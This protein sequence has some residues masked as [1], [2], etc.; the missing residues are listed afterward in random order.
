MKKQK[1]IKHESRWVN[2][3]EKVSIKANDKVNNKPHIR[4]LK[5]YYSSFSN[6]LRKF[7]KEIRIL[8]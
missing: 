1:R 5:S 8:K 3:Y 2:A 6:A 4:V 7:I